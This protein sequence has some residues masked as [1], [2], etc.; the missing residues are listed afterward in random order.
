MFLL[1]WDEFCKK[2]V[3][4]LM[5]CYKCELICIVVFGFKNDVE[6][7]V[8][9]MRDFC[10]EKKVIEGEF[11]FDFFINWKFFIDYYKEEF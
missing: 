7:V 11:R 9:K 6:E 5:I 2:L 4:C 1:K 8:K 10:N 3:K